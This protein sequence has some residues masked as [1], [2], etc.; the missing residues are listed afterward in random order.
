MVGVEVK[1]GVKVKA[2]LGALPSLK[3]L[4]QRAWQEIAMPEVLT[5]RAVAHIAHRRAVDYDEKTGLYTYRLLDEQEAGNLVTNV[6]RVGLHT[7]IYGTAAQRSA[8]TPIVAGVGLNYIG[9]SNDGTAVAAGDTTLT[10]EL[11]AD[12]LARVQGTVTLPTSSGTITTIAT[13]FTYSGASQAVQKTALFDA[14]SSGR[15][16][17]AILFTQRTLLTG[18]TL[19][20]TFSITLS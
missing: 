13:T 9:L 12:G 10:S 17:H 15:M 8:A 11:S 2:A 14:S 4:I 1:V 18:D 7:Y 16:A 19:T 3:P 20:L 6:G 5:A